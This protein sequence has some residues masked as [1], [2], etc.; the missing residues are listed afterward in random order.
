MRSFLGVPIVAAGGRDRRL[1]P[2]REGRRRCLRRRRPGADRAAG[3]ARGDRDHQRAPVRA[4]PRAVDAVRAQP[5]RARAARRRQPEAVR[6]RAH[7]RVGG[8]AV[9]PRRGRGARAGRAP[10]AS[11]RARRST[12]CARWSSSCAR[13]TSSATASAARC[14][15]TPSC[16]ERLHGVPIELRDRRARLASGAARPRGR[17][18]SPRRRCTTPCAT[19]ARRASWSAS[20]GRTAS[21]SR[22]TDDGV[23][24]RPGAIRSCARATSG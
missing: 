20:R 23:G 4:Q 12:S 19:R 22:S 5:A 7:G 13:P 15:S 18:G 10:A 17:C 24:L 11:W 6:A 2:D 1:L 8:D 16:S 9:R 14:A 21:R 3:R